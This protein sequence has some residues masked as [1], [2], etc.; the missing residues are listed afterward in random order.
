VAFAAVGGRAPKVAY[1]VGRRTGGAVVRNRLRR[2]LRAAVRDTASGLASGAY[3]VT[4]GRA[5]S[6]LS[7]EELKMQV[8]E[9]MTAAAQDRRR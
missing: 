9:A 2:R 1:T 4:A 5:A 7:F 6:E 3:L 8:K